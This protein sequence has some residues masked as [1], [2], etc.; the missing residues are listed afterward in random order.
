MD[1]SCRQALNVT[2]GS[3]LVE[4]GFQHS[5]K[6]AH[7][8]LTEIMQSLIRQIGISAYS[9]C[10]L[11]GRTEPVVEDVIMALVNMGVSVEGIY[12]YATRPGRIMITPPGK[13]IQPKRQCM[14]Q[15]GEKELHPSHIPVHFPPF[16]DPH[17]YIRTPIYKEPVTKYEAL[18]EEATI[19]KRCIEGALTKF[20]AK[21]S[22][23]QSLFNNDDNMF[24]LIPCRFEM[25]PYL[26]ALLMASEYFEIEGAASSQC[27]NSGCCYTSYWGHYNDGEEGEEEETEHQNEDIDN[28]Y[29]RP[30]TLP[31]MKK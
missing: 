21:T 11:S 14:L 15:A 1:I 20:L 18:R 25:P 28:P 26:K 22:E 12:F 4:L 31:C 13:L 6:I 9:Y 8:T 5:E 2:V 24:P 27:S 23:M 29:L 16:P 30:P 17:T 10:E 7:E 19:Q 3:L